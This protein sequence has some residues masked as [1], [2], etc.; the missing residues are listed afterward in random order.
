[1]KSELTGESELHAY[2]KRRIFIKDNHRRFTHVD[3]IGRNLTS[4]EKLKQVQSLCI[5][6]SNYEDI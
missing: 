3:S 4:R 2:L 5:S 1:M 6:K